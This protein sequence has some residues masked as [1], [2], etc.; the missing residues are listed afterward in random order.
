MNRINSFHEITAARKS[1]KI[2]KARKDSLEATL[3]PRTLKKAARI[4]TVA[5]AVA[6]DARD[7]A[8]AEVDCLSLTWKCGTMATLICN[9]KQGDGYSHILQQALVSA[10]LGRYIAMRPS[11]TG[12]DLS[13][14]T[15]LEAG[16]RSLAQALWKNDTVTSLNISNCD[17]TCR[18][19][20]KHE[21]HLYMG[22][23]EP[24]K[25]PRMPSGYVYG[26]RDLAQYLERTHMLTALD[27]SFNGLNDAHSSEGPRIMADCLASNITLTSLNYE[28]NMLHAHGV[29]TFAKF[30]Q[31]HPTLTSLDLSKNDLQTGMIHVLDSLNQ[32]KARGVDPLLHLNVENNFI[33]A[34]KDGK[35]L[36]A[37]GVLLAPVVRR[38]AVTTVMDAGK[39]GKETEVVT[40]VEE[41]NGLE[42]LRLTENPVGSKD[43]SF[44]TTL[45]RAFGAQPAPC[46]AAL[47]L[48]KCCMTA[49][50][51]EFMAVGLRYN[52]RLTSLNLSNN[53]LGHKVHHVDPTLPKGWKKVRGGDGKLKFWS[54]ETKHWQSKA[55][56]GRDRFAYDGLEAVGKLLSIKS[57]QGAGA[58]VSALTGLQ[59]LY[60]DHSLITEAGLEVLLDVLHDQPRNPLQVLSLKHNHLT[61]AAL[62]LFRHLLG[63][64]RPPTAI[65]DRGSIGS[66]GGSSSRPHSR[67]SRPHSKEGRRGS[68]QSFTAGSHS[69]TNA[70]IWVNPTG[71]EQGTSWS[72][73]QTHGQSRGKISKGRTS[74]AIQSR[75]MLRSR[76]NNLASSDGRPV[77]R[78]VIWGTDISYTNIE[79]R[80]GKSRSGHSGPEHDYHG[81]V[82]AQLVPWSRLVSVDLG[83]N[84]FGGEGVGLA[85]I[86]ELDTLL[87]DNCEGMIRCGLPPASPAP[88]SLSSR[89]GSRHGSRS[90]R[91]SSIDSSVSTS[92]SNRPP[93]A[94]VGLKELHESGFVECETDFAWGKAGPQL[95]KGRTSTPTSERPIA[96][97]E[98]VGGYGGIG[99]V[100]Y[101]VLSFND[102][103]RGVP[104]PFTHNVSGLR[105]ARREKR[106]EMAK[107]LTKA[108]G[109][110]EKFKALKAGKAEKALREKAGETKKQTKKR[111]AKEQAASQLAQLDRLYDQMGY[112]AE[113]DGAV[114]TVGAGGKVH[115]AHHLARTKG[116]QAEQSGMAA[117]MAAAQMAERS[118]QQPM[119]TTAV[120]MSALPTAFPSLVLNT[121]A[122][123][124]DI[125][126]GSDHGGGMDAETDHAADM[127]RFRQEQKEQYVREKRARMKKR[128]PAK[129]GDPY[130][131][132]GRS[133]KVGYPRHTPIRRKK[134]RTRFPAV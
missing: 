66:R 68:Q 13:G 26:L 46:L 93:T 56:D 69:R 116:L 89:P 3:V 15:I 129:A 44:G 78:G 31:V 38:R 102:E 75:G 115:K 53:A 103:T 39:G 100:D 49:A 119:I 127:A 25:K 19:A 51:L 101:V 90:S 10:A 134:N 30:L 58:G 111:H 7:R 81:E 125:T 108:G 14:N 4:A 107:L 6:A 12:I 86:H 11:L 57:E 8:K 77:S 34:D 55:P 27:L 9:D 29:G 71:T 1:S 83:E 104:A 73:G 123:S 40:I 50:D 114:V 65:M 80:D 124:G 35:M 122:T 97:R 52:E 105:I 47:D 133:T 67:S 16:V 74:P 126:L 98:S 20:K 72:K 99:N 54:P 113:K 130:S 32:R 120:T 88:S 2:I 106:G 24:L 87:L 128:G 59:E 48:Q 64:S 37:L 5:A 42:S 23:T 36:E 84:G 18:I 132:P 112:V 61:N 33:V 118:E 95:I 121:S 43:G 45:G 96:D 131:S 17:I 21:H 28:G 63:K 117:Q 82:S 70:D 110:R 91:R 41:V 79:S 76:G 60:L 92:S 85:A 22:F 94:I 62:S 109:D